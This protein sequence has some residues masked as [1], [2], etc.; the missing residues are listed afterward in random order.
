MS[1]TIPFTYTGPT[2]KD[3][4]LTVS[5]L[6]SQV[7]ANTL[8]NAVLNSGLTGTT[9]ACTSSTTTNMCDNASDITVGTDSVHLRY[10]SSIQGRRSRF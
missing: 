8:N 4:A 10:A 2:G 7:E 1:I 5:I 6:D 9:A 3:I